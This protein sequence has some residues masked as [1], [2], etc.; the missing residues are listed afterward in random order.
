[1][2]SPLPPPRNNA[3]PGKNDSDTENET[4]ETDNDEA[5]SEK[6]PLP[7][8]FSTPSPTARYAPLLP[9]RLNPS[10]SPPSTTPVAVTRRKPFKS[11]RVRKEASPTQR[12]LRYKAAA[13]YRSE[14]SL[15]AARATAA[16]SPSLIPSPTFALAGSHTPTRTYNAYFGLRDGSGTGGGSGSGNGNGNTSNSGKR[17]GRF[18]VGVRGVSTSQGQGQGQGVKG[19]GSGLKPPRSWCW[20]E[21]RDGVGVGVSVGGKTRVNGVRIQQAGQQQQGQRQ[22]AKG[23]EMEFGVEPKL[24]DGATRYDDSNAECPLTQSSSN[25]HAVNLARVQSQLLMTTEPGTAIAFPLRRKPDIA[26][27]RLVLVILALVCTVGLVRS[28]LQSPWKRSDVPE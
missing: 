17:L 11:R 20:R 3:P 8:P 21:D 25:F 1:M 12:L 5:Q 16:T 22:L 19:A 27:V 6:R 23:E 7:I 9:S 24:P 15:R 10:H 13:A 14:T 2:P 28:V 18:A 26:S 4:K